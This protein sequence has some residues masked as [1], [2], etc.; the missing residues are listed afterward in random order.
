LADRRSKTSSESIHRSPTRVGVQ[1]VANALGISRGTVDRAL[2]GRGGVSA[3]TKRRVL[4]MAQRLGYRPNLAARY[5][6]SRRHITIGLAIPHEVASFYD[7]VRDGIFEAASMFEPLGVKILH[8]PYNRFGQHEIDAVRDMLQE[9]VNGLVIS[10]AYPSRLSKSIEDATQRNIPVVCVATDAPGTARLTSVSVDPLVNGALAGELLG[11]FLPECAEVIVFIG[12]HATVDHEQKL[13]SFRTSFRSF[14]HNGKIA[15]VVEAHDE[16]TEAH[17]K[18]LKVLAQHPATKGIYVATANS[19]PVIAALQ[20]LGLDHKMKVITTDLFPAMF[21]YIRSK[22]IAATIHQRAREQG[23]IAFQ[24]IVRFLTEG[25]QPAPQISINPAV[26]MSSNLDLF[27]SQ[28][29]AAKKNSPPSGL[30]SLHA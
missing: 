17:Q 18:S 20:E 12:M 24:A 30:K 27:I 5:L 9:D 16:A 29:S 13:Q 22:T 28:E 4:R 19:M 14:C 2:H 21:Q 10:P 3:E 7:E 15:A 23:A 1:D 8:R 6:S 11:H 26:V 25:I